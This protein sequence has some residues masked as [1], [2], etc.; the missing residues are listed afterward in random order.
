MDILNWY[1]GRVRATQQLPLKDYFVFFLSKIIGGF[2][3]G[4]LMASYFKG[5]DLTLM[6]WGILTI[7]FVIAIPTIPKILK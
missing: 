7:A 5:I 2:A 3:V 6:G 4:L 1:W